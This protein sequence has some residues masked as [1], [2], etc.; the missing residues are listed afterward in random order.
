[1]KHLPF[2]LSIIIFGL[3]YHGMYNLTVEFWSQPD[4]YCRVSAMPQEY[5][6]CTKSVAV[7]GFM[8]LIIPFLLSVGTYAITDTLQKKEEG[9]IIK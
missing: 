1:M 9:L 6:I 8:V 2:F 4:Q 5:N 3:A 7:G